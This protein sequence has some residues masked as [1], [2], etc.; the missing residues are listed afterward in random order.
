VADENAAFEILE[1]GT[2]IATA[3][4]EGFCHVFPEVVVRGEI[5]GRR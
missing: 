1:D 5:V 3:R 2:L 4:A